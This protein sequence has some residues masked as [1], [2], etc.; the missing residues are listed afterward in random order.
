MV[1]RGQAVSWEQKVKTALFRGSATGGGTSI[2]DNQRLHL[3]H[4]S[5]MWDANVLYNAANEIDQ[6][7]FLD[8]G[9]VSWNTRDKVIAGQPLRRLQ[10][11]ARL[12]R[13]RRPR[14]E[15]YEQTKY[16]YLV[17]VEGHCAAARYASMMALESVIIR[18]GA[19]AG[20]GPGQGGGGGVELCNA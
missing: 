11:D 5:A 15:M 19:C 17:Y 13:L 3:A 20:G 6:V 2:E 1:A 16:R 18:V 14:I 12:K 8:A 4:L 7:P 10:P 9:V